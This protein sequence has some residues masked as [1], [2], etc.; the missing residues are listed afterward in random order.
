MNAQSVPTAR[1]EG[2]R[3]DALVL[4]PQDDVATALRELKAG[5]NISIQGPEGR[6]DLQLCE[7]IALCHKLSLRALSL[8]Q[9]VRKY[10]EIIGVASQAT[11]AGAHVHTHNLKSTRAKVPRLSPKP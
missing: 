1:P 8:G 10:G 3:A 5:E 4:H 7:P 2:H 11:A 6:I 9:P